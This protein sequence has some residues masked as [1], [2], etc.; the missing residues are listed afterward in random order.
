M[1]LL[2]RMIDAVVLLPPGTTSHPSD[3]MGASRRRIRGSGDSSQA[4]YLS[5][6][7]ASMHVLRKD[8][9]QSGEVPEF[10]ESLAHP[11]VPLYLTYRRQVKM[12]GWNLIGIHAITGMK[13]VASPAPNK[14]MHLLL[15]NGN[16]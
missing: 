16:A 1:P 3:A 14:S 6:L 15:P 7:R 13:L 9:Y 11:L 8:G 4:K 5:F 12:G 10:K 2:R